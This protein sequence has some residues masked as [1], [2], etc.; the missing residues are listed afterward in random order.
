MTCL[1]GRGGQEPTIVGG[2]KDG[3]SGDEVG[4]SKGS[5]PKRKRTSTDGVELGPSGISN[6]TT[7]WD[8]RNHASYC[9]PG[10]PAGG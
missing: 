8:S 1:Q 6:F 2:K 5:T 10:K 9:E 3:E 4:S 7:Y